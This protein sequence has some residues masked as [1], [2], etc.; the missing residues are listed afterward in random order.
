MA[1]MKGI[2]EAITYP[3]SSYLRELDEVLYQ[4]EKLCFQKQEGNGSIKVEGSRLNGHR[5][6]N[7]LSLLLCRQEGWASVDRRGIA[8]ERTYLV[9]SLLLTGE[10]DESTN[11]FPPSSLSDPDGLTESGTNG[12]ENGNL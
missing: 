8:K 3:S 9:A 10:P 12:T 11:S 5:C 6:V 7:P 4:E 1:R 2:Q